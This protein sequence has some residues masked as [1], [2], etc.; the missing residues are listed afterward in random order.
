[1]K[2]R[3][4]HS[5]LFSDNMSATVWATKLI[6]H[7][8][9]VAAARLV[10]AVAMQGR[11]TELK[12]PSVKHWPGECNPL[13]D[14]TTQSFQ[15]YNS[16][17]HAGQQSISHQSFLHLF[18]HT[19]T[20]PPQSKSWQMLVLDPAP[21]LLV[22]SLLHGKTSR[23]QQ[24]MWAPGIGRWSNGAVTLRPTATSTHFSS[25]NPPGICCQSRQVK[26]GTVTG[27]VSFVGQTF[28]SIGRPPQP[29]ESSRIERAPLRPL[30][31]MRHLATNAPILRPSPN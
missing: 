18:S 27:I 29:S 2:L 26:V 31:I 5:E 6:V 3:H 15:R 24:W 1:M 12:M 23:L 9:S 30:P 16:G 8:D 11:T 7:A 22:I 20:P 19:Y 21:V 13:A 4:L 10:R 17:P 25:P 28:Q 14:D